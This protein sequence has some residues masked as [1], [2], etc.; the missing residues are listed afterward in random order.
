MK[1]QTFSFFFILIFFASCDSKKNIAN[2][3]AENY[4]T[5][6]VEREKAAG[7][8][9]PKNVGAY[10][11]TILFNV[12]NNDTDFE[13]GIQGWA[14]IE[15]P[16][17][18]LVGLIGREEIV[19]LETKVTIIIDYPLTN[20]YKFD[21]ESTNGFT[22]EELL[23]EISKHYY[24]LYEEEEKTASIKTLPMEKRQMY[25]RNETNGKYGIWGHDIAD[26]V[27]TEISV[28]KNNR[29][30]ITLILTVDS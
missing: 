17:T 29:G 26:L 6:L 2:P 25:N 18:N 9:Q 23:L 1:L 24:K 19:I 4:E 10:I 30:Q 20:E 5:I 7:E 13:N 14:S 21:I 28:F 16:E 22:R 12:K 3:A 8:K 15:K 11:N 27:L